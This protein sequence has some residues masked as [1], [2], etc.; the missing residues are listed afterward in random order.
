MGEWL[1]FRSKK[2]E[3]KMK[4]NCSWRL[5]ALRFLQALHCDTV[6]YRGW[7]HGTQGRVRSIIP[8]RRYPPR[9]SVFYFF[10][11]CITFHAL[12]KCSTRRKVVGTLSKV[13][14]KL[15]KVEQRRA[16]WEP[17]T[18]REVRPEKT[19]LALRLSEESP[20]LQLWL[21]SRK[22]KIWTSLY[23]PTHITSHRLQVLRLVGRCFRSPSSCCEWMLFE[24]GPGHGCVAD[25][26]TPKVIQ[27]I[28]QI[29]APS[30]Y[31]HASL[32]HV[33]PSFLFIHS[34]IIKHCLLLLW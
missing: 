21:K 1:S 7:D 5:R 17:W 10:R 3:M 31:P 28:I 6:S 13:L 33:R 19:S 20:R 2:D 14:R 29:F 11:C 4:E 30:T 15:N 16:W 22:R 8:A 27:T 18:K 32:T 24:S 9:P 26:S 34:W 12:F 25:E 23:N